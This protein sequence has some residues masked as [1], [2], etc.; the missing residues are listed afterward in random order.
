MPVPFS[1]EQVTALAP[2]SASVKAGRGLT[3]PSKWPTL[4]CNDQA[5]WGECQGSGS[6]P[7]QT[8]VDFT[9]P[10]FKCSCPSRKFP[11][12]HGLGLL[13]MAV[14]RPGS[15]K[16]GEPPDWV[17]A[18][19]QSRRDKAEKKATA[20]ETPK[21]PVDPEAAAKRVAK[22]LDRMKEGGEDLARWMADQ[23]RHGIAAWPQ[24][25]TAHWQSVAS[26]MV[27]HQMPGLESEVRMLSGLVHMGE[28]W[29]AQAMMQMGRLHTRLE[30]LQRFESLDAPL[31]ADLRTALGWALDKDEV[32]ANGERLTDAWA[33]LGQD[34]TERERLWERRTWLQGQRSGRFALILDFSHGNRAFEVPLAPGT[35][36]HAEL[37]YYPSSY[38]LRALLS[39]PPTRTT[40][41]DSPFAADPD[42]NTGLRKLA[43]ALAS[44]PWLT[45]FPMS[46]AQVVPV[47]RDMGP[48]ERALWYL[49]DHTGT[50]LPLPYLSDPLH[51]WELMAIS[52]G[53]PVTVFGQWM[54]ATLQ[55]L[56]CWHP[57]E[58]FCAFQ[59]S[60]QA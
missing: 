37:I 50:L 14:D 4:G 39:G 47:Y 35:V 26:R 31:Q 20:A 59:E 9:G 1:A 45:Q 2:D 17:A 44:N 32:A 57:E 12:K 54:G 27:D 55:L 7:Y 16:E 18:W 15:L 41:L 40:A 25:P 56:S 43:T 19:L 5:A 28:R 52:G 21:A 38:P 29:P 3:N 58:G 10:G 34:F 46:L 30:G 13:F 8:Q 33:V 24:Q 48:E 42:I 6:K 60:V 53:R 22:R 36:S 51:G 49:R 11:C 23:V